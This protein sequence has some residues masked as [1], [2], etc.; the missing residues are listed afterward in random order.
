MRKEHKELNGIEC[1]ECPKCKRWLPLCEYSLDNSNWD[2]LHGYCK[3]CTSAIN[4]KIYSNNSDAKRKKMHEY[5]HRQGYVE[6]HKPYNPQYYLS[7]TAR[8]KKRARD[9][10]RRAL[11]A[12]AN[13]TCR[14]TIEI[15]NAV[16]D[17]YGYRC[18]YC[19][20]DCS[21]KYEIDHKIPLSRNGTNDFSNLALSCPHCNRSKRNKTDDEYCGHRV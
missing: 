18:A 20:C 13:K 7:E 1:K 17:K 19:G 2:G 6:K 12:T 9:L 8:A 21:T 3:S 15:I 10:N 16:M 4:R 14:I 11:K 5:R